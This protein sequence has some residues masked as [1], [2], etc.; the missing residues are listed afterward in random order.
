MELNRTESEW[1]EQ[2]ERE[3]PKASEAWPCETFFRLAKQEFINQKLLHPHPTKMFKHLQREAHRT[4]SA[5]EVQHVSS[6]QAISPAAL[7]PSEASPKSDKTAQASSLRS[8]PDQI[9]RWGSAWLFPS[10]LQREAHRAKSAVEVQQGSS[11]QAI[12]P[13][14]L[15]PSEAP[16]KPEK[17]FKHLER[18]AHRPRSAVEVQQG[19]S[20]QTSSRLAWPL[21][22]S[23]VHLIPQPFLPSPTVCPPGKRTRG[24]RSPITKLPL[25]TWPGK[26]L[27][28]GTRFPT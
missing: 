27:C 14:V 8:P 25:D 15:H 13:A 4:R 6:P 12:S 21:M 11:P 24:N 9:S 28:V 7:H 5:V 18:Q 23:M 16:S 26:R 19:S 1:I 17:K 2:P 10:S 22:F 3:G 20:P